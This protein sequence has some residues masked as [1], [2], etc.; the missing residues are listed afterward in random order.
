MSRLRN[1][2]IF[3]ASISAADKIPLRLRVFEVDRRSRR[4]SFQ[5]AVNLAFSKYFDTV[6][7]LLTK[8]AV[9]GI[10][11]QVLRSLEAHCIGLPPV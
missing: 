3:T 5:Y 2:V 10:G 9:G 7:T 1:P 8:V 11:V 4:S 6:S